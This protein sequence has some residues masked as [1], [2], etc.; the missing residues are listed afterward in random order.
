MTR[1]DRFAPK[2][3]RSRRARHGPAAGLGVAVLAALPLCSGCSTGLGARALRADRPDYNQAVVRSADAEMLLN[4]VRLRYD[5]TPL[6]LELG[7][8]V[9]QYGVNGTLTAGGNVDPGSLTG[10]ASV[11][12]TA[13]YSENPTLTLSPLLGEDFAER[14]LSPISLD[15]ILL[16][17]QSGWSPERVMRLAIA[18]V[19]DLYNAPTATGP[20]PT[21]PPDHEAFDAFV[22]RFGRLYRAKLA[23]LNWEKAAHEKDPP[24]RD[25]QFWV[26]EPDDP[27]SPLA[28]DVAA[29]RR[30]LGLAPGESDFELSGFPFRRKPNEVGLRSRSLLAILYF[31]STAVDVPAADVAAGLVTTTRDEAGMP[32]DWSSLSR[33]LMTIH[34]SDA[35]PA[36]AYVAVPYRGHWFYIAD[37]DRN[38]KS[39]FG[40]VNLLFSLQ[41]AASKGKTP[42]LTIPVGP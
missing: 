14:M 35:R 11:S 29:L 41:S 30:E 27:A 39:S 10:T 5:D 22:E 26:R 15:A 3:R 21:E 7:S 42:L 9:S 25:P 1:L 32:F 16:L 38:S 36:G 37:D 31:L 33:S 2:P 34:S 24:G 4:L 18:R 23:G 19:N 13:G 6:F 40:F 28:A 20:T 8:I 17:I 12:G